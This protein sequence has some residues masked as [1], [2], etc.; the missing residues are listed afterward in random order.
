MVL[1]RM[2]LRRSI[3]KNKLGVQNNHAHNHSQGLRCEF[4]GIKAD[5]TSEYEK[6]VVMPFKVGADLDP[7]E[8]TALPFFRLKATLKKLILT[9]HVAIIQRNCIFHVVP[10][11]D[12]FLKIAAAKNAD[13]AY[14]VR[15]P[16]Q[17]ELGF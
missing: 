10:M 7:V 2:N 4:Q 1:I 16:Q 13:V 6:V 12:V 9:L 3:L 8:A 14:S 17:N 5:L 15:N 11:T